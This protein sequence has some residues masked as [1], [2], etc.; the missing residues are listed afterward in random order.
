MG[1]K[2]NPTGFRLG[3]SIKQNA[4]GMQKEKLSL[5]SLNRS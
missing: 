1:Q 5:R 3:T 4:I 2:V